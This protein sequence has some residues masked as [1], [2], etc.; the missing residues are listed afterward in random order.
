M[1]ILQLEISKSFLIRDGI[2]PYARRDVFLFSHRPC[3]HVV[4]ANSVLL[5]IEDKGPPLVIPASKRVCA[6]ALA[7]R[8]PDVFED[9]DSFLVFSGMTTKL[10]CRFFRIRQIKGFPEITLMLYFHLC[11]QIRDFTEV[12][13]DCFPQGDC[14]L[15]IG[16]ARLMLSDITC[17]CSGWGGRSGSRGRI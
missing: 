16:M 15:G 2:L 13:R 8:C 3:N 5:A 14:F 6:Q 10:S 9:R 1:N 7:F 17:R 12:V 4:F 11:L